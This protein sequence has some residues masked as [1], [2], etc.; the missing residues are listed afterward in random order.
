MN[1]YDFFKAKAKVK[2]VFGLEYHHIPEPNCVKFN[3]NEDIQHFM[4]KALRAYMY[5]KKG[6]VVWTEFRA[7]EFIFDLLVFDPRTNEL[8]V[9]EIY[10]TSASKEEK[11]LELP[12]GVKFGG[13]YRAIPIDGIESTKEFLEIIVD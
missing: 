4:T 1:T 3:S 13:E 8:A 7:G 10:N 9:E 11:K 12:E 2:A 6:Y 5:I